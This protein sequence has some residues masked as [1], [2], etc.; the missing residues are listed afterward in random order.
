MIQTETIT[1]ADAK[2]ERATTTWEERWHPLREEWV[3]VAAHRQDRPWSGETVKHEN[4]T[5]THL[6]VI[7]VLATRVLVARA[8][9]NMTA[10]SSSIMIIRA[11]G[12]KRQSHLLS[13]RVSIEIVLHKG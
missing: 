4:G 1:C 8:I 5:H 6:I 9:R 13:S 12:W 7:F 3:V 10:S 2:G 11:S